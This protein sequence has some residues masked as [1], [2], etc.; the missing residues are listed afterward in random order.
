LYLLALSKLELK[1]GEVLALEDSA[2]GV[3]AAKRAGLCCYAIPSS[4][5]LGQDLG[6]A[7]RSFKSAEE[8]LV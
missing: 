7:D 8:L 4:L 6:A 5:S 2:V 1:A 3:Q